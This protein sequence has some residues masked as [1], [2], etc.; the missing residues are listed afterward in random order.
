MKRALFVLLLSSVACDPSGIPPTPPP[1]S[2]GLLT[3]LQHGLEECQ[4]QLKTVSSPEA[5]RA[6]CREAVIQFDREPDSTT[7]ALCNRHTMVKLEL[8]LGAT[9][10]SLEGKQEATAQKIEQSLKLITECRSS[11]TRAE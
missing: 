5:A 7:L 10:N 1:G 2:A 9:L 4:S 6:K 11:L 3:E 8:S